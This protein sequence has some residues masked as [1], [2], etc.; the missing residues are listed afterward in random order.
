MSHVYIIA[1][2]GVNHNGDLKIAK[3]MVGVAKN[4]GV[5]AIKFQTFVTENLVTRNAQTAEYQKHNTGKQETQFE[6]LKRLELSYDNYKELKELCSETGIEFL[7]TPFDIESIKMLE[8]LDI[9][10]FKVP[11]GEITNYPYLVQIAQTGKPIIMSSGMCTWSE[12]ADAVQ[13]LRDHGTTDLSLL[14]CTTEY[15]APYNEVNLKV[16]NAMQDKFGVKVGYSDHTQGI[17]VA[18]AAVAMGAEIIEKHFTLSREMEGPDHK[19]SLEP[20][21]LKSMVQ[22]IRNVEMAIGSLEKRPSKSE[23]QNMKVARKSIVAK[24]NIKA[25]EMFSEENLT[26]KRPGTGLSPM[27]WN[28][29]IGQVAVRNFE[30]DECI[31]L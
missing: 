7:S 1:E 19:A 30:K 12:I 29:V 31:R 8:R 11:S 20:Q 22:A 25:G 10:K 26:T 13:V 15:P 16:I 5:D 24:R 9:D 17:E 18:V 4:A 2:A 28:S 3:E 23:I 14:H 6:M 21:E 27:L